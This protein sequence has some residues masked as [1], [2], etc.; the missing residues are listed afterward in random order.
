MVNNV[1]GNRVGMGGMSDRKL[2]KRHFSC[3]I[4][5]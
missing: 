1:V 2:K 5:G 3:T 4:L